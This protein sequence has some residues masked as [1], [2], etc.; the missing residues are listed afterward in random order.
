MKRIRSL[1]ARFRRGWCFARMGTAGAVMV[2]LALATPVMVTLVIG[3]V[4]FGVLLSGTQSIAAA[5]RVGAEFA[6]NSPICQSSTT[7]VYL[8]VATGTMGIHS[9]TGQCIP[10]I[11]TA[12]Q[13]AR[14]FSPPLTVT[15]A[16][17]CRCSN[18]SGTDN[19]LANCGASCPTASLPL[20]KSVYITVTAMQSPIATPLFPW[21][22][23]PTT[24]TSRTS[25]QIQ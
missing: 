21:P 23:F 1:C 10:G 12:T 15:A 14:P 18:S 3:G 20:Y 17:N 19:P 5:T 16:L 7:G 6:H 25:L 11:Q 4:D 24:L 8:D 2:E 13:N 9:G 22:G